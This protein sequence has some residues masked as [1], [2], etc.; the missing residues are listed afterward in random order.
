MERL[1]GY[2]TI[3]AAARVKRVAW[4]TVRD[5]MRS[6]AL[7]TVLLDHRPLVVANERFHGWEVSRKR[8]RR[9]K[10]GLKRRKAGI[11]SPRHA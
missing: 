2:L 10:A 8:Q 7:D 3:R 9:I 5:A 11:P 4:N 1:T 6:G